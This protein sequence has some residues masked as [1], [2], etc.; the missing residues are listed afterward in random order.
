MLWTALHLL[1]IE[2]PSELC[3]SSTLPGDFEIISANVGHGLA[4][5]AVELL[6]HVSGDEGNDDLNRQQHPE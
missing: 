3:Q 2:T 1:S 6:S 4:Q 5:L